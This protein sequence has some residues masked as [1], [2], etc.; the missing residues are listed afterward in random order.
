MA[1]FKGVVTVALAVAI[2]AILFGPMVTAV[3]DN[4]GTQTVTNETVTADADTYVDLDGFQVV[5]NSETVWGYNDTSGSY[6]QAAESTDYEINNTA[7]TIQALSG[8]SLIDDGEEMKVSY[9]YEAT[10]GTTTMVVQYG[11]TFVAVLLLT[12]VGMKVTE[13]M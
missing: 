3:S 8:S 13:M 1:S 12:V 4:T 7:G 10:T 6:E 9:D 5:D 2:A 11:P